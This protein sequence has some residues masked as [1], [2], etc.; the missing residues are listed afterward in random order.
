MKSTGFNIQNKPTKF[1]QKI[2]G[3]LDGTST[4]T[5]CVAIDGITG[6]FLQVSIDNLRES[7][8]FNGVISYDN[9]TLSMGGNNDTNVNITRTKHSDNVGGDLTITAGDG[10]GTDKT[11][12]DL[13]LRG[14]ASTGATNGGNIQFW[15]TARAGSTGSGI[16]DQYKLF[17]TNLTQ[18]SL[19]FTNLSIVNGILQYSSNSYIEL[20]IDKDNNGTAEY[21]AIKD[22]TSVRAL[23][24]DEGNLYLMSAA[25]TTGLFLDAINS[26]ISAGSKANHSGTDANTDISGGVNQAGIGLTIAGGA[27]TGTGDGGGISFGTYPAGASSLNANSTYAERMA[28]DKDGNLSVGI[29]DNSATTIRRTRHTDEAGG[30]LY[31]RGGDA[32]GTDKA[33]GNLQLFG[34]R[35][36]SNASGGSVIIKTN[37]ASGSSGTTLQSQNTVATFRADG[38]TLLTG[39]LIFEGPTPDAHETTFSITD[40][41]AD[42]TITVPNASGTMAFLDSSITG[43]AATATALTSGDKTIEGNLRI[44]GSG[45]TEDN[46]VSIDAQNG[47]DASGGGITF[48]ET[49]TYSASAP[50]YGA[51]IVYNEDDDEFAMGTMHN[52]T[53][54][55]QI[56]MDRGSTAVYLTNLV[57]QNDNANGP[58]LYFKNLDSSVT[59]GQTLARIIC[60]N[61]DADAV[62]SNI[63]WKATE[64]HTATA[65]GTK[66]EFQTTPNGSVTPATGFTILQDG[67]LETKGIANNGN[68]LTTTLDLGGVTDTTLARSAAGKVTI[69]GNE[70]IT[71]STAQTGWHG[72]ATRVKILPRDFHPDDGGRPLMIEDDN[73]GS[74]QLNLFS[75]SSSDMFASLPIPS[76][77]KATHAKI[78]GSDTGQDFYVYSASIENKTIVDV[79]TGSTSI[80]TEKTLATEVTSS[81]TNYLIIRV[82]SDGSDDEIYGGYI[83]IVA[84]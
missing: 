81:A 23:F 33:G 79:A 69:E 58:Y 78:Y 54:M 17:E 31:I 60:H 34:G 6:E 53:F 68:I 2:Y 41:T 65:G 4:V 56:H 21:L 66:I 11:G 9:A 72:S 12:G 64:T 40:P 51:K 46:W 27:G 48:Y 63:F 42:R 77:F 80:G 25:N 29:D 45:D 47:G 83:T 19:D 22:Y 55:R 52:N 71:T 36:T 30:D 26:R 35:S 74:N 61:A 62:T 37:P 20:T 39:N 82:T 8:M 76:G 44:G 5:H 10:T 18:S 3:N 1:Q 50:Q 28:M 59:N 49:G 43:N 16:N 73:I 84:V 57:V 75:N 13:H 67:S 15:Q 14:G 7:G 24:P 38:D 32:T 70:I